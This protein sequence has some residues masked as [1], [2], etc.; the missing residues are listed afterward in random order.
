MELPET[1]IGFRII[2]MNH[3]LNQTFQSMKQGK[4]HL[5]QQKASPKVQFEDCSIKSNWCNQ[6]SQASLRQNRCIVTGSDKNGDVDLHASVCFP[7]APPQ[8]ETNELLVEYSRYREVLLS[9][10]PEWLPDSSTNACQAK[11]DVMVWT[12]TRSWLNMPVAVSMEYEIY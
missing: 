5:P 9:D 10:P 4:I 11:H 12:S 3:H 6:D 7:S 1:I 8:N 2:F